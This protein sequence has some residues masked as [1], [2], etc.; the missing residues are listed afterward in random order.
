M[1]GV[2]FGDVKA[3]HGDRLVEHHTDT[4]PLVRSVLLEYTRRAFMPRL[5]RVTKK[6]PA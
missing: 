2:V 6:A 4:T 3:V 5:A 1:L